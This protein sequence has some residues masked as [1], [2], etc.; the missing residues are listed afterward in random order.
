VC[1]PLRAR[2][3]GAGKTSVTLWGH[4]PDRLSEIRRTRCNEYYL[5]TIKLPDSLGYEK[6]LATAI[7]DAEIIVVAVPSKA[8][9]EVTQALKNFSGVVVSVTK[10]IE[11]QTG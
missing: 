1:V 6:D 3:R 9:R 4:S 11:H 10:G 7:R 2:W 8:F 5:P